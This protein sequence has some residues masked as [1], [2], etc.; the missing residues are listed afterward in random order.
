VKKRLFTTKLCVS[1]LLMLFSLSTAEVLAAESMYE[2]VELAKNYIVKH[3]NP[4]GGWPLIPGEKSD[5]EVTAFAMRALMAT[6]WGTGSK[7]IRG[8]VQYLAIRQRA[9]GSWNGNT[10]HTIFALVALTK[11]E[12]HPTARFNGLKW[13][14]EAQNNNGSWGREIHQAGNPLYTAAVLAG[15]KQMGFKQDFASVSKGADWLAAQINYDGGW[16]MMRGQSSDVMTTSWVLQ[17]LAVVYDI[18]EQMIWLKQM[19]NRDGGFGRKLDAPS[20]PEI[21]A[22]AIMALVA[23]K[24]PLNAD[25]VAVG[26]LRKVQQKDGSYISATPIELK[27]PA[28]NLQTTCFALLA[29]HARK[30]EADLEK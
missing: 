14:R 17:G 21:T 1:L 10:A 29:M 23:G 11:A 18:T 20:D 26:Y 27:Q 8:G 15:F 25:K 30:M 6:G 16:T 3:R 5:V 13:L 19:Q 9:D 28:A 22:Y 12:T 24:D 4:D 2:T 7:V